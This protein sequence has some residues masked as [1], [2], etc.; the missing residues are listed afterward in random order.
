VR[1][2]R[3]RA[4]ALQAA[5]SVAESIADLSLPLGPLSG[6]IAKKSDA[7]VRL[8]RLEAPWSPRAKEL[9]A[10]ALEQAK[11]LG[12]REALKAALDSILSAPELAGAKVGL[13]VEGSDGILFEHNLDLSMNPASNAKLCTAAFALGVLEPSHRFT[14][15]LRRDGDDLYLIGAFD[16]SM[17]TETLDRIA[18]QIARQKVGTV[19]LDVSRFRGSRD[20][21]GF[22]KYG[23]QDWQYLAR[24]EALA[25]NRN[26][27]KF[28]VRPGTKVGDLATIESEQ[29]AFKV[30]WAVETI[31]SGSKFKLG[32]DE[33]DGYPIIDVTGTIALDYTKGKELVMKSPDPM[34]SFEDELQRACARAGAEIA[35]KRGLAPFASD[36]VHRHQSEPLSELLEE[37]I[38]T[39]NAFDHEMYALAAASKLSSDGCTSLGEARRRMERFLIGELGLGDPHLVNAS[40]IG[41]LDRIS[42]RDV[43]AILRRAS[44]DEKYSALLHG[45]A[46][47]GQTGT[48]KTRMLG[49]RA[50]KLLRAKTGTGDDA[51]ALSGVIGDRYR[52][53]ALIDDQSHRDGVRSVLDAIGI[54]LSEIGSRRSRARSG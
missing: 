10:T 53:T 27:L 17:T 37:S 25:V 7:R 30:R 22:E 45:L 3:I 52:F 15:E 20:P 51:V 16:P 4:V 24:P 48:L 2:K 39:S 33:V 42:P 23:D 11:G 12:E 28:Y 41:N 54:V 8:P 35:V 26:L 50:E 21:A 5:A 6:P 31:A 38:A 44:Q 47:P 18:K 36:L 34:A 29:T 19:I 43:L 40:G 14:T 49:T 1:V 9:A 32:I 13:G 46:Q